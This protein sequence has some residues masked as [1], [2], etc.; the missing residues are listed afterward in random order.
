MAAT[1]ERGSV[2][3][4][5]APETGAVASG[6][7]AARL[8]F[9]RVDW[10]EA[11]AIGILGKSGTGKTEAARRL[12]PHYLA[13]SG[14]IV[15]VVDDKELRPRY[16]GQC[17]ADPADVAVRPPAPEPRVIVFRGEPLK[18]VGVDHEKVAI[19][20]QGLAAR[21]FKT[22]CVHDEMSDA[23]RYGHWKAGKDSLLASQFV[24]GRVI[25]VGKIWLTQLPQFI[26]DEPWSQSTAILCFAVDETTLAR[27][28]RARFVDDRHARIIRGLPDGNVPPGERGR[29]VLLL[30]ECAGDGR[31]YRF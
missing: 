30:P 11:P 28:R 19:Y 5:D 17:Y 24:K 23:A 25:G 13:R 9:A 26:P 14:G 7:Q 3:R 18:M 22:V 15:L 12:I 2:A 31:V 6:H 29:F 8:A 27:L 21:G 4:L 1:A 10:G 16:E 20:Q